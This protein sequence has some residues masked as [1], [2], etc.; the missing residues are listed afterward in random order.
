MQSLRLVFSF[1]GEIEKEHAK[2]LVKI[3]DEKSV[4]AKTILSAYKKNIPF[5]EM[6]LFDDSFREEELNRVSSI[7]GYSKHHSLP[8]RVYDF[9]E[10]GD[11]LENIDKD[12]YEMT[13]IHINDLIDEWIEEQCDMHG[14]FFGDEEDLHEYYNQFR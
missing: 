14:S 6:I 5:Y 1:D 7:L 8:L 9:E 12:E 13:D 2:I 4:K 11:T 3:I 10:P